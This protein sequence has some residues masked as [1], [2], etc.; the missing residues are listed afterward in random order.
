M[1]GSASVRTD[2]KGLRGRDAERWG[3]FKCIKEEKRG[4]P[5]LEDL[6]VKSKWLPCQK[7][8]MLGECGVC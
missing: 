7:A 8:F 4:Q 1:G 3:G 2:R 5:Q 6:D